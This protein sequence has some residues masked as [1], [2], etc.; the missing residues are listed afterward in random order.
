MKL[1]PSQDPQG[2]T[3]GAWF[4]DAEEFA[5]LEAPSASGRARAH[6]GAQR[7]RDRDQRHGIS[8]TDRLLLG[9]VPR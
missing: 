2:M 8:G 7:H 9:Y 3:K 6:H 4:S 5:D 1:Q